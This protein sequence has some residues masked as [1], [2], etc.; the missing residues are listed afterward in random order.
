MNSCKRRLNK[1]AVGNDYSAQRKHKP[2]HFTP[3]YTHCCTAYYLSSVTLA[4]ANS[5]PVLSSCQ[6]FAWLPRSPFFS[7]IDELF[8][9][10]TL[11]SSSRTRGR[12][13]KGFT[14]LLSLLPVTFKVCRLT[15]V[16]TRPRHHVISCP[17]AMLDAPSREEQ[18]LAE[19][20]GGCILFPPSLKRRRRFQESSTICHLQ[21]HIPGTRTNMTSVMSGTLLSKT[22]P[23]MFRR[24]LFLQ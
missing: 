14:S 9:P 22:P 2:S 16:P 12:V 23:W 15:Y 6:I 8:T 1:E 17:A 24:F 19:A 13:L 11:P 10:S 21:T 5:P 18:R 4:G 7:P 3:Q 20:T